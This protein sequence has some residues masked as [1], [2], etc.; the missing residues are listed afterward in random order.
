MPENPFSSD[1]IWKICPFSGEAATSSSIPSK[2]KSPMVQELALLEVEKISYEMTSKD[3]VEL[4]SLSLENAKITASFDKESIEQN[5]FCF[6]FDDVFKSVGKDESE[7]SKD[8]SGPKPSFLPSLTL[9]ENSS[10][11]TRYIQSR[12]ASSLRS[13][14]S[15]P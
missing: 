9:R 7:T 5:F 13:I 6:D 11:G 2:L 4:L 15:I 3:A 8:N 10:P 1:S 14:S 12:I